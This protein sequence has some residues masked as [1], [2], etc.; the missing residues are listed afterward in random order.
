MDALSQI[1]GL[2]VE[3]N[4]DDILV[5]YKG[6]NYWFEIKNPN[7]V[8]KH[9]KPYDKTSKT[10][11]KQKELQENWPGHYKIVSSIDQILEDIGL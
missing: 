8:D 5:G 6:L 9:G 10:A 3:R 1:P 2:S 11:K 7:E 4:H